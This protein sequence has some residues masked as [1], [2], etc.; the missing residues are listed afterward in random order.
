MEIFTNTKV[1]ETLEGIFKLPQL[2][3]LDLQ[4]CKQAL[5]NQGRS[6]TTND[7]EFEQFAA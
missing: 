5:L 1:K 6:F 7:K 3:P 4:K 2:P